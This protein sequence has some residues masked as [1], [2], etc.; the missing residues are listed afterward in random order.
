V[1]IF[2]FSDS[3][4][5]VPAPGEGVSYDLVVCSG[6]L[7]PDRYT[8]K[9]ERM[10]LNLP[11]CLP[12]SPAYQE[13]WYRQSIGKFQTLIGSRPFLHCPGN[14]DFFDPVPVLREAGIDAH[15]LTDRVVE[16][17]GIR[18]Y[19]FPYVPWCGGAYNFELNKT[20]ME[21]KVEELVQ[22]IHA[23]AF[24]VLVAHCPPWQVLDK[25]KDG[26]QY[27]NPFMLRALVELAQNAPEKLPKSYL[28]GHVHAGFGD[29]DFKGM[30][31]SNAATRWRLIPIRRE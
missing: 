8:R 25:A 15:N 2:H 27:G 23:D 18:F 7:G 6:D 10:R 3:H 19:G 11:I 21:M 31:V 26:Q 12:A 9:E 13:R 5:R 20:A 16:A 28:C 1:S 22:L 14:H 4:G 30:Y 24:D 17:C 29:G